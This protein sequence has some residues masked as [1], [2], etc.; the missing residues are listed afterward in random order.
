MKTIVYGNP[1]EMIAWACRAIGISAFRPDARAIGLKRES[2]WA[3]VVVY[4][5]FSPGS[6]FISVASDGTGKWLS[7]EFLIHAFAY[8]FLQLGQRRLTAA[9]SETNAPSI[10]FSRHC[11]FRHEGTLRH[12]G[13]DGEDTLIYGMLREECR[14]LPSG[15]S[16]AKAV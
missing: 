3:A 14:F 7:R 6:C 9:I 5:N 12:D 15:N 2:E 1:A 11:G 8:P 13:P 4:D 16:H 10:R